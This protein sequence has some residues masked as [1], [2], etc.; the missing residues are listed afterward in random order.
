[1]EMPEGLLL[2]YNKGFVDYNKQTGEI[3]SYFK[4]TKGFFTIDDLISAVNKDQKH[5]VDAR[6][7]YYRKKMRNDQ[8]VAKAKP[9]KEKKVS[10]RVSHK[11][12]VSLVDQRSGGTPFLNTREQTRM[13]R[14][15]PQVPQEGYYEGGYEGVYE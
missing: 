3:N 12:R 11:D 13:P 15:R 9:K 14:I 1:M 10:K 8:A 4:L 2:S 5:R 7:C 6:T